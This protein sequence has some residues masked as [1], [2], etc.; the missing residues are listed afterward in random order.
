MRDAAQFHQ[1][2]EDVLVAVGFEN[3]R[4]QMYN[5]KKRTIERKFQ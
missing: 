1:T 2:K 5:A 4:Y 3:A